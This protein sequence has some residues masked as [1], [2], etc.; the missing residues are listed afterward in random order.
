MFAELLSDTG[1]YAALV[2]QLPALVVVIPLVGAVLSAFFSRGKTS[3]W[4]ATFVT[5][6]T[7][8]A[9][10]ALLLKVL[11]SGTQ[12]YAMGGWAP[13][14]GIELR[15]DVLSA[16]IV[17]L[18]TGVSLAMMPFAR[19]SVNSEVDQ[20]KRSWFY[21]MYLVCLTGLIG[22]ALTGDAFNA[23][24][25][26]EIS[27]LATYTMIALGNDRRSLLAAYQYLIM[28]TIGATFYVIGVGL[29]FTVTGTL[30]LVDI[31]QKLG[32]VPSK[33]PVLAALC[34]VFVGIGLKLALFPMHNWLPNAYAYAP[35]FASAFLAATATKVAVYLLMRFFFMV[36][37]V[38][39]GVTAVAGILG[40]IGTSPVL[41]V[42]FFL[43]LAAMIGPSIVAV[44]QRNVKRMLAY[45]SI[46]QVGYITLGISLA[47]IEGLMGAT[48]HLF[49]HAIMKA[50]L[51]LSIGAMF[52]RVRTCRIEDLAGIGRVMPVTMACFVIG[53][54]GLIGVPGTAGFISKWYL[55]LGALDH[56]MWWLVLIIMVTSVIAVLYVGRMIEAAY[57]R[58]P[59]KNVL[60]ASDPPLTILAPILLLAA[61]T[62]FFGL[63]T[64]LSADIAGQAA[65]ILVGGVS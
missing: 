38:T 59:S 22:I 30:N 44:F 15:V 13:P 33:A 12:S 53:G 26:L 18:V 40:R 35:S 42:M 17:F 4:F 48:T 25:F 65:K 3:W 14:A 41:V 63:D 8:I 55:A 32:D 57:F 36:F 50:L 6:L 1:P 43:S 29:L 51:F 10:V 58:E 46:S 27:S 11:G 23:F 5:L 28:G 19:R 61:A 45:S 56:G 7:A 9:G 20:N 16:F 37:D 52:Y 21:T 34:F 39:E 2:A 60:E 64:T 31:A 24:V 62:I 54:L 49:N 47:N